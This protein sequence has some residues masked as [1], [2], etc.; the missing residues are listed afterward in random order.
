MQNKRIF[1]I[2][3]G[4]L[5]LATLCCVGIVI[6]GYVYDGFSENN[7]SGGQT[8]N[9]A[10]LKTVCDGEAV[11]ETAAYNPSE[12]GV[13]PAAIV[14][15]LGGSESIFVSTGWPYH[16]DNLEEAQLV[17]CLENVVDTVTE[18]CEYTLE[19]T[20]VTPPSPASRWSQITGLSHHKRPN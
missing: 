9:L 20:Q 4:V 19:I 13:H 14:Q 6:F 2:V 3:G 16:P 8:R 17:V 10:S 1:M 11:A 15:H 18:S 12:P 7:G 5:G